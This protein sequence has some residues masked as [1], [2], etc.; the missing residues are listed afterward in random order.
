M[1]RLMEESIASD[2]EDMVRLAASKM[3]AKNVQEENIK[4]AI[5]LRNHGGRTNN[6]D[7][8]LSSVKGSD[9][10]IFTFSTCSLSFN[11]TTLTR[12]QIP[13]ILYYS[14]PLEYGRAATTKL[15]QQARNTAL[16]M[17]SAI[18]EKTSNLMVI[19]REKADDVPSADIL[20]KSCIVTTL[21]PLVLAH[22]SPLATSDSKSAVHIL[23]LIQELLPHVAALNLMSQSVSLNNKSLISVSSCSNQDIIEYKADTTSHHYTLVESDHPYKPS[24]V[25][26]YRVL[27]P[28]SVKWMSLDFDSACA[29]VQPEDL[30]Q[31]FVPALKQTDRK[32]FSCLDDG[33]TPLPYW[34]VLHKFSGSLQWPTSS[35]ILPGNEVIFSLET[36]SDYL[37]DERQSAYGFKCLVIGYEWP[38]ESNGSV[39]LEL[40]H[41]EA[42]LSFL[43]EADIDTEMAENTASDI[44]MRHGP[45][46][47]K[48]LA[49]SSPPTVHQALDGMLPYR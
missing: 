38:P 24:T 32:H 9:N 25:S 36:A 27:F 48:G 11:G 1:D 23:N 29:T 22:I 33:E 40:K 21:L 31:L 10:T 26:N 20:S 2:F 37:K 5:R 28:E 46:L 7:G 15:E 43:D 47:S 41:L 19:A 6:G 16:S 4:Y 34:P 44:F 12:G 45:L 17:T 14:N 8:G 39:N 42:E 3:A 18:I 35:V 13:I 49:L 30:L